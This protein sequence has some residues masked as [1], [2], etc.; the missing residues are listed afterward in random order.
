[1][2]PLEPPP[3]R[4]YVPI[5]PV[6]SSPMAVDGPPEVIRT[7]INDDDDDDDDVNMCDLG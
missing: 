2:G 7:P 6:A 3:P 4:T 5:A 1:M